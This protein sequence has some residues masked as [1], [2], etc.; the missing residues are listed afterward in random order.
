MEIKLQNSI[1]AQ[2]GTLIS[3][4]QHKQVHCI[5]LHCTA[6]RAL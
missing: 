3:S 2:E 5:A 4:A 1:S 6:L